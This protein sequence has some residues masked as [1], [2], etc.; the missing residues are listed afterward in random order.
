MNILQGKQC[1][2]DFEPIRNDLDRLEAL[3]LAGEAHCV[4]KC[5]LARANLDRC[6]SLAVTESPPP[7][8]GKARLPAAKRGGNGTKRKRFSSRHRKA[9]RG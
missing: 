1:G 9:S 3:A 2:V 7:F 5:L 8:K 4:R 6:N